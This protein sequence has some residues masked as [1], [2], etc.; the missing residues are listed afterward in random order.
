MKPVCMFFQF[1]LTIWSKLLLPKRRMSIF[2]SPEV[3]KDD[4]FI[5]S[6]C[7]VETDDVGVVI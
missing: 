2:L 4:I 5:L 3:L 6:E 1:V 7:L